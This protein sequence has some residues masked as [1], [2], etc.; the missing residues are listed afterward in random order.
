LK[1]SM[2]LCSS[3][4]FAKETRLELVRELDKSGFIDRL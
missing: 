3:L 1:Q 4:S 2:E